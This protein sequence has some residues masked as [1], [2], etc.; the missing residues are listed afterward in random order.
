MF[1]PFSSVAKKNNKWYNIEKSIGGII[2]KTIQFP[3]GKTTMSCSFDEKS[4]TGVLTSSIE[5]YVPTADPV[6]LVQQALAN[7]VNSAPLSQ[8]ADEPDI[9]K[10]MALFMGR[11]RNATASDQGSPRSCCGS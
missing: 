2:I 6:T 8:L 1:Y 4:L 3:Y 7:P 10:T 5:E 9:R 11:D